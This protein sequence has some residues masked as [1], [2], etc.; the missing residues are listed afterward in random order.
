M[1]GPHKIFAHSIIVLTQ[2]V[3]AC[4]AMAAEPAPPVSSKSELARTPASEPRAALAELLARARSLASSGRFLDAYTLLAGA[5]DAY[6]GIIEF[7]YALGRAALDAGHPDKATLALYRVLALDPNH[8]GALIDMGRAY[9]ALGNF[10]Q[11]RATFETLLGLDP[12]PA[13]RAQLQAYLEQARQ[14]RPVRPA[15]PAQPG[16]LSQHGYLAAV[17]GRSSNVNQSPGQPLVFVPAFGATF[18][19][20]DQNVSKRDGFAGLMGG[21]DASLPLN[22]SYSIVGG[23]EFAERRNN[24]ESAFNLGGLG[25]RLGIAAASQTQLLR[26]QLL[27]GRDYLGGSPSR[28]MNALGLDYARAVGAGTQLLAFTQAGRLRYLPLELRIF[29]AD[30]LMLGI[31]VSRKFA[32]ESTAFVTVSTGHQNDVGGNPSGDKRQLGLRV[33]ADA[34]IL[35]RL[36]LMGSVAWERGQYSRFDPSFLAERRDWL[37]SYELALQYALGPRLALRFGLTQTN[38]R[39]N[40][41]IYEFDRAE[42]SIMLRYEFP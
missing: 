16:R 11:A 12:P 35:P 4:A 36:R 37:R 25:A 39:S 9:L 10:E 20:S 28:D 29:D 27:A 31:G 15:P 23:G 38:Q 7:D 2:A 3:F 13:I 22:D 42:H 32:R 24:Q 26:L 40:I 6:I 34:V 17:F 18:Q 41:S 30:F 19:L 1:R 33:G 8:A 14:E 5:E 21:V